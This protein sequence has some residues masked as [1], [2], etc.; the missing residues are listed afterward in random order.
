[1]KLQ[2]IVDRSGKVIAAARAEDLKCENGPLIGVRIGTDNP[3]QKLHEI[4][5]SEELLRQEPSQIEHDI[6]KMIARLDLD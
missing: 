2:V 3:E 5:V 4:E 6:N 1:M